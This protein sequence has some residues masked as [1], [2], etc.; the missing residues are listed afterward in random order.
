MTD[1]TV[2]PGGEGPVDGPVSQGGQNLRDVLMEIRAKR[3]AL[4][5][6]IV[7]EEA[8]DPMHPLHHR[9]DWDDSSAA[10]KYRLQQASQLLRV[11]YKHDAGDERADLR[12]FWVVRDAD[13]APTSVY[14]PTE[15]VILDDFQRDL[16]L[17]QMRRDW[18]TFKRRYAHM[19]EFVQEVL[20]D[21]ETPEAG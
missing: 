4:T 5:P 13:G 11:R 6:P 3:G 10:H 15:E 1:G 8:A 12:A 20:A 14:E 17:R 16:M 2:E 19:N 9:F 21:L 7:V 18:Q